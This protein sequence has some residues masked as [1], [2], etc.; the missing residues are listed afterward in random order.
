MRATS[1]SP[2]ASCASSR[3]S[4]TRRCARRSR[5]ARP[6]ARSRQR[7]SAT[8][9]PTRTASSGS[10]CPAKSLLDAPGRR[11]YGRANSGKPCQARKSSSA[12][13]R[14]AATSDV[15]WFRRIRAPHPD[16]PSDWMTSE[17]TKRKFLTMTNGTTPTENGTA[18]AAAMLAALNP[19]SIETADSAAEP[20]PP[21]EPQPPSFHDL[22]LHP[23][24]KLALDDMGYFAPTPVHTAVTH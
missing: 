12:V 19:T 17:I 21:A 15:A 23:D 2:A 3:S 20:T 11:D 1:R 5:M 22:G 7:C 9:P 24:V 8:R 14:P 16:Q 13:Q 6:G 18:D 4:P 10:P